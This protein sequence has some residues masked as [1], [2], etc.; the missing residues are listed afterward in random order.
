MFQIKGTAYQIHHV[1]H[2]IRIKVG[3]IAPGT[4]VP[5]FGG[6]TSVGALQPASASNPFGPTGH[7]FS[8]APDQFAAAGQWTH[9]GIFLFCYIF[10]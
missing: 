5:P 10:I 9:S 4:P 1:Q 6:V 3:D 8:G 7:Q 2:I